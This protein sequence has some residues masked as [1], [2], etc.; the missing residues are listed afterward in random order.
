MSDGVCVCCGGPLHKKL[1][2][3][4]FAEPIRPWTQAE[5]QALV[6][7]PIHKVEYEG[8]KHIRGRIINALVWQGDYQDDL[9]CSRPCLEQFARV[10]AREYLA[11]LDDAS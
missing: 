11:A 4:S 10:S 3:V 8:G 9:F 6:E 1:K 2:R 7:H 5:A